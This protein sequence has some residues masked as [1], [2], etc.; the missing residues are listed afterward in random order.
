MSRSAPAGVIFSDAKMRSLTGSTG[1]D[2]SGENSR[3]LAVISGAGDET[4]R[5][6]T[7]DE[8]EGACKDDKGTRL[9]S[10]AVVL[11]RVGAP[12]CSSLTFLGCSRLFD[13]DRFD[14]SFTFRLLRS[15]NNAL[16]GI[17]GEVEALRARRS[18][19]GVRDWLIEG[20]VADRG[21]PRDCSGILYVS[22]QRSPSFGEG[23]GLGG[24]GVRNLS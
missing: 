18:Y 7:D 10:S 19:P 9:T 22:V 11:M 16:D 12:I 23:S 3:S 1:C 17:A 14:A 20:Y 6:R 24:T 8:V 21:P 2:P 5:V 4:E 15:G 13:A